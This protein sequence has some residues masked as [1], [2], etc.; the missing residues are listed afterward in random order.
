MPAD[1]IHHDS[2]SAL[3][4]L[5]ETRLLQDITVLLHTTY[6]YGT[7]GDRF[8]A[9]TQLAHKR[10]V[11]RFPKSPKRFAWTRKPGIQRQCTL[12]PENDHI[13]LL[14]IACHIVRNHPDITRGCRQ[15]LSDRLDIVIGII[16]HAQQLAH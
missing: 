6:L 9:T 10:T 4:G 8:D 16:L 12:V 7:T 14:I 1:H 2:A 3:G 13:P 11:S 15:Y 5:G